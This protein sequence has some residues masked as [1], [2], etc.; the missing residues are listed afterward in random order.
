MRLSI[1]KSKPLYPRFLHLALLFKEKLTLPPLCGLTL[2]FLLTPL[3]G[4]AADPEVLQVFH[5][6]PSCLLDLSK[7]LPPPSHGFL[8]VGN[9]GHFHWPD[10]SRARFWGI[11][12]SST[13]LDI[14]NDQIE[15]VVQTFANA[16]IN[17]VRLE[18]IDNRNCLLGPENAPDSL[19]FDPHYLDR[20][21]VWIA[22]LKRYHICYY[23][24][25]LDL[26]P[27]KPGDGVANADALHRGARPYALFDPKLIQLQKQYAHDL[28]CHQNPYTGLR[29]VD[30]PDL[31]MG[32]ICN[33]SGFFLQPDLLEN[34]VEPYRT[35]LRTLWN[36]WLLA[37][38]GNRQKLANAWGSIKDCP[39]LR[40]DE[41]PSNNS[42]DLPLLTP[43]PGNLPPNVIDVRRAPKRVQDGVAFLY[44]TERSYFHQMVAYLHSI[45]LKIPITAVVSSDAPA[46]LAAVTAECDFTAENWYGETS[47]PDPQNPTISYISNRDPLSDDSGMGFAPFTATLRWNHKPVVIREW[48]VGWPNQWRSAAVPIVLAYSSLQDYDAVLL[49]GYQTNKGPY[50]SSPD[51]LNMYAEQNDPA[52]W[53]LY[54]IAGQAFLRG[55]IAPAVHTV[56]LCFP[57]LYQ[58]PFDTQMLARLAWSV[59]LNSV[60]RAPQKPFDVVPTGTAEDAKT[61]DAVLAK[62]RHRGAPVNPQ[63]RDKGLWLS[64]TGQILFDSAHRLLEVKSSSLAL[65]AGAFQPSKVYRIGSLCFSTPTPFGA[66]IA[67]ALDGKP[68]EKSQ[69]LVIKM[70]SIAKNTEQKLRRAKPGAPAPWV[71]LQF[72]HP[73]VVTEGQPSSLPTSVWFAP[74][75]HK[76]SVRSI[77]SLHMVN[78]TWELHIHGNKAQLACD[79]PELSVSVLGQRTLT[80][81]PS[82]AITFI[83][84]W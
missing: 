68:L 34:M 27:F 20:L 60:A 64:D 75:N 53:G 56:T 54:A 44:Q 72:G 13:R 12:V 58:W 80:G 77:L 61:L 29:L 47:L 25:L 79:T 14:P 33:E 11:N 18:A 67:F 7:T 26:R 3:P 40:P 2:I 82:H 74:K 5:P 1:E 9:D 84:H 16:G 24:D 63:S 59:R 41:D 78:G 15:K 31:A 19:H 37:R 30:D 36:H 52:I 51:A 39:V 81:L 46:D 45:G 49:F 43:A 48:D 76:G 69:N 42:V 17:L 21:D 4:G 10:G 8:K 6:V 73:P 66:L 55:A 35:E 62:L 70:V 71:L 50:D 83:N 38:Y 22:T 32:E 65:I 28:L 57:N 23:L